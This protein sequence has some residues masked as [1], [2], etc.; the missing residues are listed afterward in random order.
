M[1]R[2]HERDAVVVRRLRV[3][4]G[5]LDESA[6]LHRVLDLR[7]CHVLALL[8]LDEVLLAVDDLHAAALAHLPDVARAEVGHAIRVPDKLA[9]ILGD[10]VRVRIGRVDEVALADHR[11]ADKDLA[12]GHLDPLEGRIR[13][14]V[15]SLLPVPQL[16]RG[17]RRGR[18]NDSCRVL[19]RFADDGRGACLGQTVALAHRAV[20][21]RLRELLDRGRERR[22]A[23][24]ACLEI[25]A[26]QRLHLLEDDLII[27]PRGSDQALVVATLTGGQAPLEQ[28]L[29]HRRGRRHLLVQA[30]VHLVEHRGREDHER[31]LEALC[32]AH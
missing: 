27:E 21:A 10:D 17:A 23:G 15:P 5:H 30:N 12:T 26:E 9:L 4:A 22:R 1:R 29:H 13:E 32:V 25:A 18:P 14:A 3:A 31:R 7:E 24:D 11:A 28:L 19:A 6:V 16:D 20:E 8:Q 2:A